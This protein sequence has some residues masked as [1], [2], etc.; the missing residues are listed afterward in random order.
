MLAHP[1]VVRATATHLD[2]FRLREKPLSPIR[3]GL[4][5]RVRELPLQQLDQRADLA[6]APCFRDLPG[7]LR[8]RGDVD[9]HRVKF[10]TAHEGRDPSL[11][12]LQVHD[13]TVTDVR[14]P[15]RQT[16]FEVAVTLQ[17]RAPR[18]APEG[19]YDGSTLDDHRGDGLPLL[20]PLGD[21]PRGL[22]TPLGP[23]DVRLVVLGVAPAN[24]C[25]FLP[26]VAVRR[27][28]PEGD[29]T[30]RI[31]VRKR[32]PFRSTSPPPSPYRQSPRPRL[33]SSA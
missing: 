11:R 33:G 10:R 19:R 32:R 7:F 17:V 29:P 21:F 26:V 14:P 27:R 8:E 30:S 28:T 16:V 4:H 9:L 5:D 2:L 22:S 20:D 1:R 12:D 31:A 18:L 3:H 15:A 24:E 23:R 6:G 13:R 25:I